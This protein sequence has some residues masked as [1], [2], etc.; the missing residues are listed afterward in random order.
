MLTTHTPAGASCEQA[1]S[2]TLAVLNADSCCV[3]HVTVHA[4]L[5]VAALAGRSLSGAPPLTHLDLS[6]A[7]CFADEDAAVVEVALQVG[8]LEQISNPDKKPLVST[9]VERDVR[10][11]AW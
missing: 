6:L 2:A 8:R 3:S 10:H 9:N 4:R 7:A 11:L 1:R 5:P